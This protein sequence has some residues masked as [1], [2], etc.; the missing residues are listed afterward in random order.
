MNDELRELA[1]A[2]FAGVASA[3]TGFDGPLWKTLEDSGLTRL[4]LPESAGGSGGTMADAAVLLTAAGA[5]AARVPLVE[6]D[7]LAGWLAHRRRHPVARRPADR[8]ARRLQVHGDRVAGA[9]QP[10]AVG[11]G[12]GRAVV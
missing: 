12:R 1:E 7:L 4:T 11:Q 8:G 5:H 9:L 2:V 3:G 6:T 10:G